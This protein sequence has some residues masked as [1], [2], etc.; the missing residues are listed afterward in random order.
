MTNTD[1]AARPRGIGARAA[2]MARVARLVRQVRKAAVEIRVGAPLPA[3]ICVGQRL[4]L[5]RG[6]VLVLDQ[7][8]LA[9][10]I[11]L[12]DAAGVVVWRVGKNEDS[13]DGRV[14]MHVHAG[15]N[16]ALYAKDFDEVVS[17][18]RPADGAVMRRGAPEST[19]L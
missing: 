8:G 1:G 12:I 18:I 11:V 15:R 4:T 6:S 17:A 7:P 10:N 13:E 3:G 9:E 5:E 19:T 2:R 14:Y 16:G